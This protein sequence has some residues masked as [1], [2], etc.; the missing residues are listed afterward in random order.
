MADGSPNWKT[1]HEPHKYKK[2]PELGWGPF[3]AERGVFGRCAL[4]QFL[5]SIMRALSGVSTDS[6]RGNRKP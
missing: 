2:A 3:A 6:F 4:R 1:K 5:V